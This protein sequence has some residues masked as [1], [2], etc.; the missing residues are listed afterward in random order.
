[1]KEETN[2]V[3]MIV[4]EIEISYRPKIKPAAR[5]KIR[6]PEDAYHLLITHWDMNKIELVEE[7]KVMLLNR[8]KRVL[9]ICTLTSGSVVQTIADPKQVFSVALKANATEIIL[10]HNHPSGTLEPSVADQELTRKMKT[11]GEYLE[12]RVIDHIIVSTEGYYS[13]AQE[14]LL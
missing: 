10:V 6:L 7:F 8:G 13:F 5:P 9:G 12:L 3:E 4:A 1:M 2:S 14:G 11:A